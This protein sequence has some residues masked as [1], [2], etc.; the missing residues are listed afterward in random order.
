MIVSRK[1]FQVRV[2]VD[3][4]FYRVGD[5][6]KVGLNAQTP[7]HKPVEGKGELTLFRI[8]YN[9]K[10]EPVEKPVETWKLDTDAQGKATQQLK[11]AEAGQSRLSSKLTD[12]KQHGNAS[13]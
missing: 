11:A 7:D 1:P 4:G 3:R 13:K 8:S 10:A 6:V 9:E 12:A 5:T 2:W